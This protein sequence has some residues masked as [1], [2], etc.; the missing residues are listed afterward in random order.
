MPPK[1]RAPPGAADEY[2]SDGGFVANDSEE[3]RPR[4]KKV[5]TGKSASAGVG[6]GAKGV[7]VAVGGGGMR[8]GEAVFWELPGK[9]RVT[10]SEFKG[11]MLVSVREFYEKEGQM[12]PGKKGIALPVD[13]FSAI[14]QLLPHIE[15]VLKGKGIEVA[16]PVYDAAGGDGDEKGEEEKEEVDEGETGKAQEKAGKGTKRKKNFEATS[17]EEEGV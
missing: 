14:I 2:S 6:K 16:R 8:E 11:K 3:G 9:K 5:K 13:Q 10:V 12:L 4:A 15:S 7:A 17:E 1:K